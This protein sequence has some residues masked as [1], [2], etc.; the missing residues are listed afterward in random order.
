VQRPACDGEEIRAGLSY[1]PRNT[2]MGAKLYRFPGDAIKREPVS[3]TLPA[4]LPDTDLIDCHRRDRVAV[5][6]SILNQYRPRPDFGARRIM[7][8]TNTWQENRKEIADKQE[9][10]EP[11][12]AL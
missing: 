3:V 5:R 9:T 7:L 1:L 2:G 4:S 10:S 8:C 6:S 11:E 12:K